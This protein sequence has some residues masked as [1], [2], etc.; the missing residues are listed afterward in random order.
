MTKILTYRIDFEG[1]K[2][3]KIKFFLKQN[4]ITLAEF[5]IKGYSNHV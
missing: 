3:D 1:K 5:D 2:M 4:G